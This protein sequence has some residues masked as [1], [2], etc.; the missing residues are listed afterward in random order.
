MFP[1]SSS[2]PIHTAPLGGGGGGGIC[3]ERE[4][5]ELP[6]FLCVVYYS[7]RKKMC[8]KVAFALEKKLPP[9][10]PKNLAK[11]IFLEKPQFLYV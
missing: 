9:S 10:L 3:V 7:T 1:R 5:E 2:F 11:H 4:V 6:V 8:N